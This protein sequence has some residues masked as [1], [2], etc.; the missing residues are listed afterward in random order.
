MHAQGCRSRFQT[1]RYHLQCSYSIIL[2][3]NL[4]LTHLPQG[5]P[6]SVF[7]PNAPQPDPAYY[8]LG[9]PILGICY[10]LQILA[11]RSG[12][13]N[14]IASPTREFGNSKLRPHRIGNSSRADL[15]FHGIENEFTAW[16]SHGDRVA[17]LPEGYVVIATTADAPY[18]AI[19]H[20]D[21]PLYGLQLHPEVDNTENGNKILENF[22]ARICGA[23]QNWSMENFVDR[24]IEHIRQ[25]VGDG[26]VIGAVSG[27]VDSS[28]AAKLMRELFTV[29]TDNDQKLRCPRASYW[30][31]L[32]CCICGQWASTLSSTAR[33]ATNLSK[34]H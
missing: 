17:K 1:G 24:E 18:A 9:V 16:M 33:W 10:G 21:L 14:V 2:S 20:Q 25:L 32:P 6:S 11:Y 7:A 4:A 30:R 29:I 26:Q 27:G 15:L 8:D 23:N 12:P 19:A 22:A 13:E 34:N 28:V 5:G 31:S 3:L